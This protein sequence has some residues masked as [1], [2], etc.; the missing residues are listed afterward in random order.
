MLQCWLLRC[1]LRRE[2]QLSLSLAIELMPLLSLPIGSF[3]SIISMMLHSSFFHFLISC[4]MSL[5]NCDLGSGLSM[6]CCWLTA[7]CC[8]Y[9]VDG[10]TCLIAFWT[11]LCA[12]TIAMFQRW[13]QIFIPLH[14]PC[15][16]VSVIVVND[17]P[18][19][20]FTAMVH[21]PPGL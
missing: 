1:V 11:T 20:C 21:V 3:A 5:M 18:D 9:A 8:A 2:C 6:P 15:P 17:L 7:H 16:V 4:L 12:V 13:P 19:H 14:W 10:P